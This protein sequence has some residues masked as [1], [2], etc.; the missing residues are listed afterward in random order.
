MKEMNLKKTAKLIKKETKLSVKK[1]RYEHSKRVAKMCVQLC[2]K[3]NLDAKK[4]YLIG[5]AHDLCKDLPADQMILT[6]AK[7]GNPITDYDNRRPVLLHGRAAAVRMKEDFGIM[8]EQLLEAVAVHTSGKIGMNDYSKI[9][10][11]SDK[12][13]PGRKFSTKEYRKVLFSLSLDDMLAKV[14][15]ENFDF[16]VKKGYEVFPESEKVV[17]YYCKKKD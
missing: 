15:G 12:A 6:A 1:S 16:V 10:L 3:F 11:I 4:G 13:E 5:I 14:L 9:L 2:K 17:E 8:D 7:D